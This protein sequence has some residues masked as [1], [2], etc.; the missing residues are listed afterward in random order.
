MFRFRIQ[1]SGLGLRTLA[2]QAFSFLRVLDSVTF[3]HGS[4]GKGIG[5][6]IGTMKPPEGPPNP[7][8]KLHKSLKPGQ[9]HIATLK[10]KDRQTYSGR[11]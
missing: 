11:P 3:R 6:L 7:E 2:L 8:L 9:Q 4:Q 1:G 10:N 5:P